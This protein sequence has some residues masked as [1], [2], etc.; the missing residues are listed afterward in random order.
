LKSIA[1][2]LFYSTLDL[3]P[4]SAAITVEFLKEHHYLP[5]IS[6]PSS[7]SEFIQYRKL[8]ERN[9]KFRL[10][11]D[12]VAVKEVVESVLGAEWIIPTIWCGKS[13][14][15][16]PQWSIPFVMKANHASG[17]NYFVR[18]PSD[19][20]WDEIEPRV[21]QWLSTPW[22]PRL[23]EHYY[24][25]IERQVLVEPLLGDPGTSLIDYKFY[26]FGGRATYIHLDTGRMFESTHKRAFY[27][28]GWIKQTFNLKYPMDTNPHPRPL[29]FDEML[30][31]AEKLAAPFTF[32]RVDFYDLPSGPKFG[33]MTFCPGAGYERFD[34][35]EVDLVFGKLWQAARDK[36]LL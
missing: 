29:H 4:T 34:P 13:L 24:N 28:R 33:E 14:P 6:T 15:D 7:F 22:L 18:R 23:G 19:L 8:H 9:D 20:R 32:A 26:V 3:L 35:V 25:E 27:D 10:Y 31:A 12:K 36:S 30:I 5:N 17:W 11:A 2:K 1:K 21:S 16:K